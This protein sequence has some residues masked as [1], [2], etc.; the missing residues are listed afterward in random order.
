[1]AQIMH[2]TEGWPVTCCRFCVQERGIARLGEVPGQHS[3]AQADIPRL[4][5]RASRSRRIGHGL[6]QPINVP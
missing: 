1:M 6:V 3:S 5:R 4:G 2:L